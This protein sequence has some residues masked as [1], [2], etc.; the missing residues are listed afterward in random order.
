VTCKFFAEGDAKDGGVSNGEALMTSGDTV[1]NCFK[2]STRSYVISRAIGFSNNVQ[3]RP[4]GLRF[5][6]E[7]MRIFTLDS[8]GR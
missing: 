3:V 1:K 8:S 6:E 5:R 2:S 4:Q 7:S